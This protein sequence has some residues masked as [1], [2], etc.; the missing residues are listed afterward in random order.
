MSAATKGKKKGRKQL[1]LTIVAMQ[2]SK[3]TRATLQKKKKETEEE[4]E[5]KHEEGKEEENGEAKEKTY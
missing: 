1:S 3:T 4:K 2:T 5:A